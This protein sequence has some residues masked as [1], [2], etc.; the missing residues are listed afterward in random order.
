M[1][2]QLRIILILLYLSLLASCTRDQI[3]REQVLVRP[4][5]ALL[6]LPQQYNP[7]PFRTTGDILEQRDGF[8]IERDLLRSQLTEIIQWFK[9]MGE[10][11]GK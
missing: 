7:P 4:S 5:E 3:V 6:T 10:K 2:R 9:D 8:K 1:T 11:Y